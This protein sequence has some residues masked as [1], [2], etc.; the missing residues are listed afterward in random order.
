MLAVLSVRDLLGELLGW[1]RHLRLLARVVFKLTSDDTLFG[2]V[3]LD[4]VE[5][6]VL[7]DTELDAPSAKTD[8]L[9]IVFIEVDTDNVL[10]ARHFLDSDDVR[11]CGE[12]SQLQVHHAALADLVVGSHARL[13]ADQVVAGEHGLLGG[14]R[15]TPWNRVRLCLVIDGVLLRASRGSRRAIHIK[16]GSKV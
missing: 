8:T 16:S 14:L 4:F 15:V 7:A 13:A 12:V 1:A 2:E 3:E 5:R 10:G 6:L 9:H 11:V